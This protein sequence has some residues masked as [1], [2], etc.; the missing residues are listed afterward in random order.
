M[1]KMIKHVVTALKIKVWQ[2]FKN[3]VWH[4]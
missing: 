2:H 4:M 1:I 3:S